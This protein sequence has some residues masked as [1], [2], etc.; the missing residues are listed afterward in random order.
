M[1]KNLVGQTCYCLKD[2]VR[3]SGS[4]TNQPFNYKA[5]SSNILFQVYFDKLDP[6]TDQGSLLN[7]F[8]SA[9]VQDMADA[10]AKWYPGSAVDTFLVKIIDNAVCDLGGN[11]T[12]IPN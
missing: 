3:I 11:I 2:K 5:Y 12:G 10:V 1:C 9:S 6:H 4:L 7:S 8:L